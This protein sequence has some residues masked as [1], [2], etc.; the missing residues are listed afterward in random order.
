M[1]TGNEEIS[2][3]NPLGEIQRINK[4]SKINEEKVFALDLVREVVR[5]MNRETT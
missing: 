2:L 1:L 5:D 4:K 3:K